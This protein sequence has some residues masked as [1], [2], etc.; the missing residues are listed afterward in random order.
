MVETRDC[1]GLKEFAKKAQ[2]TKEAVRRAILAGTIKA[3][4]FESIYLIPKNQV[5]V[6]NAKRRNY[7]KHIQQK[8]K[9]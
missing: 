6:F 5:E 9:G 4:R 3:E 8:K 2:A 1:Y 7:P